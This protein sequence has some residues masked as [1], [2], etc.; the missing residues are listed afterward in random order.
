MRPPA[1]LA[2]F[3]GALAVVVGCGAGLGAIA[4]PIDVGADRERAHD[5]AHEGAPAETPPADAGT[6]EGTGH[7]AEAAPAGDRPGGLAVAEDGYRL[8]VPV[9]TFRGGAP[10]TFD[11]RVLDAAGDP[12][13]RF[14][15]EHEKR[16]HLVV[17]GRN[18]V[19]YA[20]VHPTLAP[21]GTWTAA[22]PALPAGSY[23]AFADFRP[24]GGDALTLG[25]DLTVT[26]DAAPGELPAPSHHADVDGYRVDL[27]GD[28]RAGT[29][30][31][32]FTVRRGGDA[33]RTEPYLGAAGHLVAIRGGDMAYLHVHPIE[34]DG[35]TVRFAAELPSPGRYRLFLDFAHDGAVHTAAFTVEVPEPGAA[36]APADDHGGH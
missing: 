30:E 6:H 24:S 1:R 26:G 29:S 21:D 19:D 32:A 15:V 34:A 23:R 18:L 4:G 17:V 25:V 36:P 2:A 16:M 8:D 27:A 33:V 22:V 5:T 3:G 11:L 14:A 13:T 20:H 7:E 31:L 10:L 28:V 12:V 9:T 35:T